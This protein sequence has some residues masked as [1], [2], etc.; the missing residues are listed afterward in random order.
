[1]RKTTIPLCLLFA[2]ML[3]AQQ[4]NDSI[5]SKYINEVEIIGTKPVI[6]NRS[7]YVGKLPLRNLE[8]SQVYTG[9]TST[10]ITQQKIYNMDDVVRNSPGISKST[11]GWAGSVMYG[12]ATY[13]SRGFGTQIKALNGLANNITMPS[14]VQNVSAIEVIKGPSATL[15]GGVITSY[16]GLINRVTKKPYDDY[17]LGVDVGAG[18]FGF[19]RIG[20]D[21][22]L[23]VNKEKTLLSRTNIALNKQGTFTENG[24]YTKDLF[25]APSFTYQ[26][27]DKVK[28]DL[29]SEF[30]AT[31]V[32]GMG[33]RIMF[34]LTPNSVKQYVAQIL[35]GAG[36]PEAYISS[37]VGKMPTTIKEG[38]GTENIKDFGLDR[39]RSF[40]N[41][42]LVTTGQTFSL[43][44]TVEYKI[45]D[46]WKSATS[47]LYSSGNDDGYE[48]RMVLL[49]NVVKGV[50]SALLSGNLTSI[51]YGTPGADY[52]GRMTRKF[53]TSVNTH[54]IQQNFVGDF[55]IANMRNRIVVGLD[56]Y[57]HDNQSYWRTYQSDKYGS[58]FGYAYPGIFDVVALKGENSNYY[59]FEKN[60]I[61]DLYQTAQ[62]DVSKK[63]FG[64]T[65]SV[66]STYVNDVLNITNRLLINAGVRFDRFIAKGI[67]DGA[68]DS[69]SE[70][71][72]QN[73]VS[74]KFGIVY[75][76]ILNTLS[77]FAN[78]QT[79]FTNKNGTDKNNNL[80]KPEHSYQF[81]TGIK[82]ALFDGNF[83]GTLSV[84]DIRVKDIV[85]S[86]PDDIDFNIQD[87]TQKSRGFEAE[88]LGNPFPNFNVMFGYAYN[89]SKYEKAD[90]SVNGLRPATAGAKNQFNVW[91][92]YHFQTY[93]FL[94]NFSIGAGGNYV[95]KTYVMNQAPD[96]AFIVPAYTLVNA[97]ISYD[98]PSYSFA[99][100][101]N[102]LLNLDIWTG[103]AGIFPQMPRQ[104]VG[105][106]A[107]KF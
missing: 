9:I 72:N 2:G 45:S 22:N 96:G 90:E 76:P 92:H 33:G 69:W 10:L 13:V 39:K 66:Y 106:V 88:I 73:A 94:N 29:S 64:G 46:K 58:L 103:N 77:V 8:N 79:G 56:Y 25:I 11:D 102:N 84:Y 18:S 100:R 67:Y 104:I 93:N 82:Y 16:G 36:A 85:R 105:S 98:K 35:A 40:Y 101:A 42:N 44:A 41:K 87:G 7:D 62:T 81:E 75:Q 97:K 63:P 95:G 54:Q 71:Y 74:P 50:I 31:E 83:T 23:P 6:A 57:F 59:N 14:D 30:N 78:Y 86:D 32:S 107:L 21:A 80:F 52:M 19:S 53:E 34:S 65:T 68:T 3:S 48:V 12:G 38:F 47:A 28:I 15:F 4:A 89:D 70:G 91:L 51:D 27:N 5:R 60:N 17:S 26:L 20:I 1:M 43:N 49:P 55:K 61:D 37:I 24:G 99:L